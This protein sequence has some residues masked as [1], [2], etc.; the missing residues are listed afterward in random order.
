MESIEVVVL[1]DTDIISRKTLE[2][3]KL[4]WELV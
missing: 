3:G 4:H 1:V 2:Q